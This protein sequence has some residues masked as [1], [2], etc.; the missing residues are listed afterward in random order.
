[1]CVGVNEDMCVGAEGVKQSKDRVREREKK[2]QT[3]E[4]RKSERENIG[5]ENQLTKADLV[6][7]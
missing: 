5:L 1:M 6:S 7:Q 4:K 2:S 3:K